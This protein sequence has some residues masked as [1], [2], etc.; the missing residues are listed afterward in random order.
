MVVVL[1]LDG[2]FT[3]SQSGSARSW[4]A[5]EA[6]S[7]SCSAS[8][9]FCLANLAA[10]SASTPLDSGAGMGLATDGLRTFLFQSGVGVPG[11]ATRL[12]CSIL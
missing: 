5:L 4:E 8:Q 3:I 9:A 1:L 12:G 10:S 11:V 2:L 6:S 7:V